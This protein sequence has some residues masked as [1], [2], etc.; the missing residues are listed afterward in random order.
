[1]RIAA[2]TL[3]FFSQFQGK[4]RQVSV[5]NSF[6]RPPWKIASTR[7]GLSAAACQCP[8][9]RSVSFFRKIIETRPRASAP[10]KRDELSPVVEDVTQRHF[11]SRLLISVGETGRPSRR[12]GPE[13]KE[14]PAAFMQCQ[15]QCRYPWR[16]ENVSVVIL[17]TVIVV[18]SCKNKR[19]SSGFVQVKTRNSLFMAVN[20]GRADAF[21]KSLRCIDTFEFLGCILTCRSNCTVYEPNCE[22]IGR[23]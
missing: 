14:T 23:E 12:S 18:L 22:G 21:G 5:V 16:D 7:R 1:M 20:A 10:M 19:E 9:A 13:K 17:G 4:E 8:S 11:Y 2:R 15:K 6:Y 3:L